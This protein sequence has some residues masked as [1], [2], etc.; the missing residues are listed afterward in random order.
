MSRS[1][2]SFAAALTIMLG[3]ATLLATPANAATPKHGFDC[4]FALVRDV[5]GELCGGAGGTVSDYVDTPDGCEF[6]LTCGLA[7]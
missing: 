4:S 2:I 1:R 7:T 5:V 3:G 6:T